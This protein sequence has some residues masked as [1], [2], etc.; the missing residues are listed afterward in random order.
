MSGDSVV[1]VLV[2]DRVVGGANEGLFALAVDVEL[3]AGYS[4]F[5]IWPFRSFWW[6]RRWF[7]P[8]DDGIAQGLFRWT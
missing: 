7:T 4:F 3:R 1:Q 2:V 6:G 5:G 8:G